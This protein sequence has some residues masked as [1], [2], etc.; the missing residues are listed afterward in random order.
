MFSSVSN[1]TVTTCAELASRGP[2]VGSYPC[3][4]RA[5]STR[6]RGASATSGRLLST[7]DAVA[8]ETPAARATT[9]SVARFAVRDRPAAVTARPYHAETFSWNFDGAL[10]TKFPASTVSPTETLSTHSRVADDSWRR[11]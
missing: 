1:T 8:V 5:C 6:R 11:R 3:S 4:R 2:V 9:L 7:F 10:T